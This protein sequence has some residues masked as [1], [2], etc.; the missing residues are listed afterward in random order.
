MIEF[1]NV[2]KIYD[3]GTEAVSG[4]NLTIEKGKLVAL[5]GPSGC[6][7]TTTMKMINKLT[8]PSGGTILIDGKD[9]AETDE[10]ELRRNIGYVIQRIGLLPHMT[11]EENIS[12]IPRLKG[13]KKEQYEGRVDELLNL[14]GLDP[15]V[16]RKRYPLELSGGQQQR[17]GVIRALAAEPPI[18]LMDEPFS[19]LDPISREQLQDELK[20]IQNTIHKTIVFVTHDIDEALKIADE[21]AVMRDGKIEQIATPEELIKNPAN[22][23]VRAFIGEHR[24]HKQPSPMQVVHLMEEDST[25]SLLEESEYTII[26]HDATIKEAARILVET[27]KPYLMVERDGRH[28]GSVTATGILRAVAS[29]GNKEEAGSV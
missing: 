23:F 15:G 25:Y 13:W 11:I 27:G 8:R 24:L 9:T 10:V 5:I 22:Q 21:I 26:H 7:K 28:I 16:Y 14:V 1:K 29:A 18:I 12:L 20:S 19:A 6:G 3:D 2:T 17:V 4:I